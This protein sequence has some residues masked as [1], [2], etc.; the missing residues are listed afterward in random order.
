MTHIEIIE[1]LNELITEL[2]SCLA[3]GNRKCDKITIIQIL[4]EIGVSTITINAINN[5][6][7]P[8]N[9]PNSLFRYVSEYKDR[10]NDAINEYKFSVQVIINI[11][12]EERDTHIQAMQEEVQKE[13]IEQ[14]KR[15][16]RIQIWTLI[17]SIVAALAALYPIIESLIKKLFN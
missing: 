1:S 10:Y 2:N 9:L 12:Q 17:C 3:Q 11:L 4:R 8:E 6:N 7:L 13:N 15:S 14:Q 5:I 16:N